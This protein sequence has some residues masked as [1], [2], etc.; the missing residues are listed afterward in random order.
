MFNRAEMAKWREDQNKDFQEN[1]ENHLDKYIGTCYGNNSNMKESEHQSP[2]DKNICLP[3]ADFDNV[4]TETP[5]FYGTGC[6]VSE[7]RTEGE[8]RTNA[9]SRFREMKSLERTFDIEIHYLFENAEWHSPEIAYALAV[10]AM[11]GPKPTFICFD[12]H[13]PRKLKI[14]REF[15]DQR[16][17]TNT[18]IASNI[19]EHRQQIFDYLLQK[20]Q[21]E[22]IKP[23]FPVD[24]S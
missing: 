17:L 15:K 23:N 8:I 11:T 9:S 14:F 5:I 2:M 4:H 19:R 6:Y 18:H 21:Q 10:M 13:C 24:I 12:M 20:T 16:N 3:K 1:W 22:K 7:L